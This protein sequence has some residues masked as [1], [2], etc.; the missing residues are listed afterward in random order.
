M[1]WAARLIGGFYV[2]AG[3][4]A[5]SQMALNW[6]L[7]V[8]FGKYFPTPPTERAADVI[9][10][11]GSAL[12]LVSG[13]ALV[14]LHSLAVPAFLTCWGVQAGYLIWAKRWYPPGNEQTARLR[15]QT[16]HAFAVYSVATAVV[17]AF[18]Q[19]AVLS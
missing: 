19:I 2:V 11:V 17:M 6:R 15:R 9:L 13:V 1:E 3:A 4:I 8:V 14:L 10:T 16:L 18:D 7:E 12:V 5:L